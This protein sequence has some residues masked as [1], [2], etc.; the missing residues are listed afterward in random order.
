[1]ELLTQRIVALGLSGTRQQGDG[2]DFGDPAGESA[3]AVDGT[4]V[5]PL[6]HLSYLRASGPDADAFLQGQLSNDL[7]QLSTTQAQ[8]SSYSTPKGRVL[9]LFTLLRLA[10]ASVLMETQASVAAETLKRL[11][12][13]VLR[14]KLRVDDAGDDA[15]ALGIAGPDAPQLLAGAGLP[16]PS[17]AWDTLTTGDILVVRRPGVGHRFS[18]HGPAT[19]LAA[20]W[21]AWSTSATPAGTATWRLLD[22]LSGMPSVHAQTREQFVPQMLNLDVIGGISFTKGCYPG[23]EI[24]ARLHY[25]GTAKRRMVRARITGP[26]VPAPGT[27][28]I[29]AGGDGQAVGEVVDAAVHPQG[30]VVMLAVL[31]TAQ[32]NSTA[33]QLGAAETAR[34]LTAIETLV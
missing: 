2:I 8:L 20:R 27:A 25:L 5:I 15:L 32:M 7:R 31:Q 33:L 14:S 22:I 30:G 16:E 4:V 13:F 24:V 19:A 10:D 9:A 28:I 23:Q 26:D 17:A 3:R 34:P 6:L 1:M 29:V 11:R 12:S 18:V 21:Q